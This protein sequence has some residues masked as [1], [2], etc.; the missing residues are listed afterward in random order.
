MKG[1]DTTKS[2]LA[3]LLVLLL[4]A[5]SDEALIEDDSPAIVQQVF[6]MPAGTRPDRYSLYGATDSIFL[7]ANLTYKFLAGYYID[8]VF[9]SE[10]EEYYSSLLWNIDGE[11]YN[12]S[13]FQ[14]SFTTP[15]QKDGFLETV[16]L[17]GDTTR[18]NFSIFINTPNRIS[19][20]FPYNG[21]NQVDRD[22]TKSILL[23]WNTSG[24]DPWEKAQ[25]TI[26]ASDNLDSIWESKL[27]SV[28]CRNNVSLGGAIDETKDINTI[29]WAVI[30]N[31]TG[32]YGKTDRDTTEIFHFSSKISQ[33]S[34][35]EIPV[36]YNSIPKTTLIQT[37]V[38]LLSASDDTLGIY[39]NDNIRGKV[40]AVVPP[41]SGVKV[42]VRDTLQREFKAQDFT[43]D[44]PESTYVVSDTVQFVDR[45]SPQ[46][47][48]FNRVFAN[49]DS[50]QFLIYDDGSGINPNK[51]KLIVDGDTLDFT[52]RPPTLLFKKDCKFACRVNILGEDFSK[53][54]IP[55]IHWFIQNGI[56][57]LRIT[58]PFSN[59]D[60]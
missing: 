35:L 42:H 7:E 31:V 4:G 10:V 34:I 41:Q 29:Y 40:T 37:E 19:L 51:L 32:T 60:I 54:S 39:Y 33:N 22:S 50:I 46:I 21:Y 48:P 30:M 38:V 18:T 6:V 58:G 43:I 27:G 11:V 25:C 57:S 5:C 12:I 2:V 56:D 55:D 28:D 8:G 24:I 52:Y 26:F 47:A 23:K 59:E 13:S 9:T 53:N 1:L 20:E 14:L 45:T 17:L 3:L 36:K 49:Q 16:D 15:G 44:I